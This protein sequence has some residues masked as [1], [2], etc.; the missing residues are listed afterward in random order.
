MCF[1]SDIKGSMGSVPKR[2]CLATTYAPCLQNLSS[3]YVYLSLMLLIRENVGHGY[4]Q[5][6]E[7]A[8]LFVCYK[9]MVYLR[10]EVDMCFRCTE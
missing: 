5:K 4:Y 10:K 9:G 3:Y 8:S 2:Y 6:S 7:A 1:P